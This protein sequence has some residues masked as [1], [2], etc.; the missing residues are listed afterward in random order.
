MLKLIF[1]Q[2]NETKSEPEISQIEVDPVKA[3][4]NLLEYCF[5]KAC[6]LIKKSDLPILS[7]H[8]FKNH[9][10][11]ACPDGQTVD[12]K[13]SSYK[14][15]SAFLSNMKSKNVIN[16]EV[17]KGVESILS[18]QSEHP[19]L[20]ELVVM[21]KTAPAQPVTSNA[22]VVAECYKVTADVLPILSKFRYELVYHGI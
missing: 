15:L 7:S 2:E 13:K 3:M 19:L 10:I 21:E 12:I 18:I 6:K 16:T 4:D 20:Q 17:L 22:P 8:F 11:A 14:K 1:S 9:L 5:L